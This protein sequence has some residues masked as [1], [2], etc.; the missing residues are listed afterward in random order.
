MKHKVKYFNFNES[1][2]VMEDVYI[3]GGL[4]SNI[5]LKN[6]IFKNMLPEKLGGEILKCLVARYDLSEI[7]EIICGNAVGTGGNITRL[8]TLYAGVS[9]NVP[10]Y[11]VDM[12]CASGCACIDIAFSKISSGQCDLI[13]AGGFESTSMQPARIYNKNDSRYNEENPIYWTAQF[14]PNEIGE[15]V[16]LEAAERV[17]QKYNITNEELNFWIL[18]S[19]KRAKLARKKEVLN[20]IILSLDESN[21]DEG[22][23][24]NMNQRLINRMKPLLCKDGKITA[25]NTCL[26]NDGAAF[27]VLCSKKFIQ[28][29]K[30][31]PI[32]KVVNTSLV[33][34]NPLY[35]P[36]SAMKAADKL[37][38]SARLTY[39]SISAFEFNEAFAVIDVMFE[40]EHPRLIDRYNKFGGALAYGHPYGA[41]G[42]IIMLHL[43]KSLQS[44]GGKYGVCAI[45][46]AGGIGSAILIERI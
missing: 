10:S 20:D 15:N 29:N 44:V 19:H 12:Q 5:G 43:I 2:A 26:I 45:A 40:R 36:V 42:G 41:S 22:I 46:A 11:T 24:D 4:R 6:G 25:A 23:R 16:M 31:K 37:L 7:D 1:G 13:I 38:K 39:E 3:I 33:G 27:I 28:E 9:E 17:A 18:E 14:S 21:Y 30:V 32:A 35:S 8:M 34:V